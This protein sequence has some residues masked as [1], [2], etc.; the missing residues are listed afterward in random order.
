MATHYQTCIYVRY[1]PEISHKHTVFYSIQNR[2][3]SWITKKER[4]SRIWN[5]QADFQ[6]EFMR[7][8][9][10]TF[11]SN[12]TC[13]T[14][15]HEVVNEQLT[16]YDMW[17]M[18]YT[19]YKTEQ[20]WITE[21]GL[22]RIDKD[23]CLVHVKLSYNLGRFYLGSQTQPLPSVPRFITQLIADGRHQ[24]FLANEENAAKLPIQ[25]GF[26]KVSTSKD[27]T[28]LYDQLIFSCLRGY[29][30]IVVNGD[31]KAE[32]L[33]RRLHIGLTINNRIEEHG[34]QSKALVVYIKKCDEVKKAL[35][36]IPI[37]YRVPFNHARV[38]YPVEESSNDRALSCDAMMASRIEVVSSLLS[39]FVLHNRESI[40]TPEEV[41]HI[42]TLDLARKHEETQVPDTKVGESVES[43]KELID[44][45]F[46]ELE[47][48]KKDYTK[49]LT[50]Q[51]QETERYKNRAGILAD[52]VEEK[53]REITAAYNQNKTLA[54]LAYPGS[55]VDIMS[56]FAK[57]FPQRIIIH[58]DAIVSAQ[59]YTSFKEF[60]R[61]WD[62]MAAISTTLYSMKYESEDSLINE[63][64]F[65]NATG[66]EITMSESR[67]TSRD[68]NL[69]NQRKRNYNGKI[70]DISPHIKWGTKPPK[71]LRLHFA[72]VEEEKKIMI[73]YF[74]EHL[75]NYSTRK[76]KS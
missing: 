51:A 4:L 21:V 15:V 58:E 50:K 35:D 63:S 60:S 7:Q 23:T 75:D 48:N 73:G 10:Y 59:K 66:F 32:D 36:E 30:I 13:V 70:Y 39:A 47:D 72:F 6:K 46:K 67:M 2:L 14:E 64:D 19:E 37:E 69:A 45:L 74:G 31:F 57:L 28:I 26:L 61:A 55:L 1:A 5:C 16:T 62:V 68:A 52:V 24:I 9:E 44:D 42:N 56:F 25:S 41:S 53:K 27:L 49:E 11:P 33:A 17:A 29:V 8:S 40:K 65:K 54:S 43:L 34:V 76:L 18:R 12:N 20:N 22:R 38:F 3:K 71:C